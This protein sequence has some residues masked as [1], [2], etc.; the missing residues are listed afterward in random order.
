[1]KFQV[2]L[3]CGNAAFEDCPG[4]EVARILGEVAHHVYNSGDGE[5]KGLCRDVNG[6]IVGEWHLNKGEFKSLR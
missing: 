6:N 4:E 3:N 1:M 2:R 5:S